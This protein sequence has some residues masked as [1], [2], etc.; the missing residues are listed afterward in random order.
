MFYIR[1]LTVKL[2]MR[3]LVARYLVYLKVTAVDI[4]QAKNLTAAIAPGTNPG[5]AVTVIL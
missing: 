1:H 3:R 5:I 2:A 4:A